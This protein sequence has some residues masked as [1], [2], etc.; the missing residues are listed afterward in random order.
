MYKN[1]INITFFLVNHFY[2]HWSYFQ[3]DVLGTLIIGF[4]ES[5]EKTL[6]NKMP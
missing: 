5:I 2:I 6:E 1:I 3:A 4:K